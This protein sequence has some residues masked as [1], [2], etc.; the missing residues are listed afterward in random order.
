MASNQVIIDILDR[1][2]ADTGSPWGVLRGG[3]IAVCR[4]PSVLGDAN[5][6][7]RTIVDAVP[8]AT[9]VFGELIIPDPQ[10]PNAAWYA[11]AAAP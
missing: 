2:H 6:A 9:I 8:P 10:S 7:C 5:E 1:V 11:C 3:P 4:G